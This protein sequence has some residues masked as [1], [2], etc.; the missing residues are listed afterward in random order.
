[1]LSARTDAGSTR[2]QIWIFFL[3]GAEIRDANKLVK[4]MMI[5][6]ESPASAP[7]W[8]AGSVSLPMPEQAVCQ[9]RHNARLAALH[10]PTD[11]LQPPAPALAQV[12]IPFLNLHFCDFVATP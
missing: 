6:A 7:V 4:T 1:M 3:T 5:A 12:S 8:E 2:L 9:I 11:D 10:L